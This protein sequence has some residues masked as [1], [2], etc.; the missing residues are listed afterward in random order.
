MFKEKRRE[1]VK[2][3]K[4]LSQKKESEAKKDDRKNI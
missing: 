1:Y 4:M 3:L 2:V